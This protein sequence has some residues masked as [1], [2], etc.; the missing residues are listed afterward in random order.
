MALIPLQPHLGKSLSVNKEADDTC[1]TAQLVMYMRVKMLEF[2]VLS[3]YQSTVFVRRV[4]AYRLEMSLPIEACATNPMLRQCLL[5]LAS[6][7][8]EDFEPIEPLLPYAQAYS[9]ASPPRNQVAAKETIVD[10][11][12]GSQTIMFGGDDG[13]ARS[14]VNCKRLIRESEEKAIFKVTWDC[15][16]HNVLYDPR[17]RSVTMVDFE[18]MQA[19]EHDTMSPDLPEMYAIFR[20]ATLQSA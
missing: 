5:A 2:G 10:E 12:I 1:T 6:F 19:C 4:D 16:Q 18:L 13:V 8:S 15:G 11:E 17:T 9:R 14:W 7:A 3:M 20:D